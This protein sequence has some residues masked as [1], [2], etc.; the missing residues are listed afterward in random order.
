MTAAHWTLTIDDVLLPGANRLIRMHAQDYRRLRDTL[1][2]L[3]RSGLRPS[4]P[5]APL[6]R[7][8]VTIVLHRPKRSL[9]DADGKYGAIKP[10]LDVLQPD[11]AYARTL[12]RHRIRDVAP[13]LGLIRD[14]SDGDGEL[15]G[16]IRD[17]RVLQRVGEPRIVID[18]HAV[19][20]P[21]TPATP[22]PAAQARDVES[23]A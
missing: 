1:L 20:T 18:V 13:G 2:M 16:C 9:L 22:D 21:A 3:A 23:A 12:G 15:D 14:D 4:L 10:L 8:D 19:A 11:R 6:E 7:C 5:D 17:L